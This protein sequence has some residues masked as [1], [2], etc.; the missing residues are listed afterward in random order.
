MGCQ[1]N[2]Q[3]EEQNN[4]ISKNNENLDDYNNNE[5]K[6]EIFGLS[7]QDG[8]DPENLIEADNE[9]END[10]QINHQNEDKNAK[11]A[12]YPKKMLELINKI[13]ANPS[14]YADVVLDGINNIIINQD[15]DETKPKIIY[16]QKVKV[17]L[18]KGEP[19]FREAA[20]ILKE[21]QPLP[22]LEFKEEI[23]VPLPETEEELNDHSYLKRQINII[24]E[25]NNIDL[26]FKDLIKLPEV[27]TLLMI[28]DDSE[29]NPGKK[30]N[31]L[32]N[33]EF[34]YIGINNKFI[35]GKFLAYFTFSK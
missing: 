15:F 29:K 3:K 10:N 12:D 30:R 23:C 28:V 22:A 14:S 9:K 25:N 27:S 21:M 13:R 35:G 4:E 31:A 8:L 26:F 2:N 18:S 5:Q 7:N 17:A 33:E 6:D 16:K 24:Q 1:C 20:E 19:A 34:K 32:L 11:Y